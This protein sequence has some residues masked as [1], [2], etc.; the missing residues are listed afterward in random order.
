M[1]QPEN[2]ELAEQC[3]DKA[4]DELKRLGITEE[5]IHK[6]VSYD[7]LIDLV[8]MYYYEYYMERDIW[9]N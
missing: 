7:N 1:S 6:P 5:T 8:T 9:T 2:E 3:S 4:I